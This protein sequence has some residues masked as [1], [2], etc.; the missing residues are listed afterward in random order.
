VKGAKTKAQLTKTGV[1]WRQKEKQRS[2]MPTQ[3][4]LG[5]TCPCC[6]EMRSLTQYNPFKKTM[7]SLFT[8][9]DVKRDRGNKVTPCHRKALEA[10]E[11]TTKSVEYLVATA[12]I[13]LDTLPSSEYR[14]FD[15]VVTTVSWDDAIEM[16]R[17]A[18]KKILLEAITQR[19]VKI[20]MM[21]RIVLA[22]ERI[23][24][25]RYLRSQNIPY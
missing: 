10:P 18:M 9:L 1:G 11:Q 2:I 3:S 15:G 25:V 23:R 21:V 6:K 17:Y 16:R 14:H 8:N 24:T 5:Y 20:Q 19:V 4:E 7:A 12:G 22:K 13:S